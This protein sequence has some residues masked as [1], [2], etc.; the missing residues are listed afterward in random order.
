MKHKDTELNKSDII[1]TELEEQ[2]SSLDNDF[3]DIEVLIVTSNLKTKSSLPSE[4][5]IRKTIRAQLFPL[6]RMVIEC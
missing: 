6:Y 2:K 3:K 5:S 1:F 4:K